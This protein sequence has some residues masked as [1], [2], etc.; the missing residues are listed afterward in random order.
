VK[1]SKPFVA[2]DAIYVNVHICMDENWGPGIR[3]RT[4]VHWALKLVF[5]THPNRF[6]T[7]NMTYLKAKP[8][9]CDIL[10][11]FTN[12]NITDSSKLI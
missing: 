12:P 10:G 5:K 9:V 1:S 11:N 6:L 7:F 3:Q 8:T 4:W 2:N